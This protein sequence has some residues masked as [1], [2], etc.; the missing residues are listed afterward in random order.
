[1]STIGTIEEFPTWMKKHFGGVARF[2]KPI[3]QSR[4]RLDFRHL[5]IAGFE[6]EGRKRVVQFI[7]HIGIGLLWVEGY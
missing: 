6:G 2:I 5:S 7:D 3:W 1:M 4:Q